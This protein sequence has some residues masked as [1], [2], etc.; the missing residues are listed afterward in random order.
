[1]FVCALLRDCPSEVANFFDRNGIQ[2]FENNP[3]WYA[4]AVAAVSWVEF[5]RGEIQA[6]KALEMIEPWYTFLQ[7]IR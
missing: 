4:H 7:Q 1:M 3:G 2:Q 6:A 5:S